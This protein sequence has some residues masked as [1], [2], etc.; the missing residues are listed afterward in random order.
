MAKNEVNVIIKAKDLAS[1]V[2][3][4][5]ERRFQSVQRVAKRV[6]K[7]IK[8]LGLGFAGLATSIGGAALVLGKLAERGEQVSSVATAFENA[9]RGQTDALQKLREASHSTISDFDLMAQYNQA[10][11]LGSAKNVEQFGQ[12]VDVARTLGRALNVDAGYA[13]RSLNTGIARQSRLWLDN[14][15]IIVG[16]KD[17]NEAYAKSIDK[18]ASELTVAQRKEAFR[19]AAL[20]AAKEA[21]DKLGV[22]AELGGTA[23]QKFTTALGNFRDKI[24]RIAAESPALAD[25]FDRLTNIVNDLVDSLS[26]NRDQII[27]AFKIIGGL[28]G[29]AFAY[30]FGKA[31]GAMFSGL[32]N[33]MAPGVAALQGTQFGGAAA[34]LS[35]LIGKTGGFLS[36]AFTDTAEANLDALTNE[37]SALAAEIRKQKAA[38]DTNTAATQSNTAAQISNG[39]GA[40]AAAAAEMRQGLIGNPSTGG[41]GLMGQLAYARGTGR[42]GSITTFS[43][44]QSGG[45]PLGAIVGGGHPGASQ[46]EAADKLTKA[47]EDANRSILNL[48]MGLGNMTEGVL[49]AGQSIEQVLIPGITGIIQALVKDD[50]LLGAIVGTAGGLLG[51]IFR[52]NES[53]PTAVRVDSYSD[54][55][56]AQQKENRGET[57]IVIRGPG[58]LVTLDWLSDQLAQ[59]ESRG[60]LVKVIR[61]ATSG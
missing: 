30:A 5:M 49:A 55:A 9:T 29:N 37:L 56:L 4:K 32:Q 2:L 24:S 52:R 35:G 39:G 40:P 1:T 36:G 11:T 53:Q 58:G 8:T 23:W 38:T 17:A 45:L 50:P 16:V 54:Q 22:S 27:Q 18:S 20:K 10:V 21:T 48:V 41:L 61:E 31:V 19:I 60:E 12:M 15:G 57:T 13:L 34:A 25:F 6:G 33:A 28:A 26:G 3:S 7:A 46:A 44:V 14:L 47:G 59:L 43:G 51:A 42:S